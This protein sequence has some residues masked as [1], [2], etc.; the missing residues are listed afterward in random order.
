MTVA[1]TA[2]GTTTRSVTRPPSVPS[3]ATARRAASWSTTT[4]PHRP[5][6]ANP[7]GTRSEE[8]TSEL[9]SRPHLVC[10][11]LLEKKNAHTAPHPRHPA[12][13][14]YP[15]SSLSI[16]STATPPDLHSFPT[17]RSSDL[18][19]RPRPAPLPEASQGR[20]ACQASPPHAEP[21]RGAPLLLLTAPLPR[22]P[23]GRSPLPSPQH[24][25]PAGDRGRLPGGAH[26]RQSLTLSAVQPRT[27]N[28][29]GAGDSPKG[30]SYA[31]EG[32]G[33]AQGGVHSASPQ[34]C[35]R[36][37]PESERLTTCPPGPPP[38][39]EAASRTPPPRRSPPA[40]RGSGPRG[41]AGRRRSSRAP[42]TCRRGCR[43]PAPHG[44]P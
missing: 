10:R 20:Q 1:P 8:H 37:S 34:G 17:R 31:R 12:P 25:H 21:R 24:R 4:T 19:R 5:A 22:T 29:R 43:T 9:Q 26:P 3:I 44:S 40:R 16:Q 2:A 27:S 18:S 14:P 7:A 13:P 35:R 36:I 39:P 41:S 11:L 32:I 28:A 33:S 6:T 30:R 15:H 23:P 42:D 38:G